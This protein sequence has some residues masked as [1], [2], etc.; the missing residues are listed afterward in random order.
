MDSIG[1][2]YPSRERGV[3]M[4]RDITRS[5]SES[6]KWCFSNPA[7][8][9]TRDILIRENWV[10]KPVIFGAYYDL[11]QYLMLVE[12][13]RPDVPRYKDIEPLV[14]R[15]ESAINGFEYK[16]VQSFPYPE[17]TT[18]K[19]PFYSDEELE[20]LIRWLDLEPE[21]SMS[22]TCLADNELDQSSKNLMDAFNALELLAPDFYSEFLAITRQ[23][24]LAKPDGR[25]KLT[26]GGASSFAL[27]GALTLNVEIH[28]D[29]WLYLPSLVH[30]YSHNV[31][32]GFAR[33]EPL[34]FNDPAD[35]YHSP[36]RRESRPMDGIY[37]AAFVS[38]REAVAMTQA[39]EAIRSKP[40]PKF[41]TG[42]QAYCKSVQESSTR[43]FWDCLGVVEG[44]GQLSGLGVRIMQDTKSAMLEHKLMPAS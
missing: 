3:R 24:I 44:E 5:L 35:T 13:K 12:E 21:N 36:L 38:A 30:E 10:A 20:C 15:I 11:V 25:Q 32:F 34:V 27:W 43:S 6:L 4:S 19:E 7:L 42:I 9:R 31:L 28:Q 33:N 22:L 8:P 29:W 18:L 16:T 39:L 1:Y 41:I 14:N 37:H 23:I 2:F 26:F 40:L 17:I